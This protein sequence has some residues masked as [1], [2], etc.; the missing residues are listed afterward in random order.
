M[1]SLTLAS[2]E[3]KLSCPNKID[4][5]RSGFNFERKNK[6]IKCSFRHAWRKRND[7]SLF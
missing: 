7:M 2:H 5:Q 3:G 4:A 6:G 1:R